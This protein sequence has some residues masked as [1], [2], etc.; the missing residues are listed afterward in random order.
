MIIPYYARNW[1]I[2]VSQAHDGRRI[3]HGSIRIHAQD[4]T[5][6]VYTSTLTD[7][8][9]PSYH[10]ILSIIITCVYLSVLQIGH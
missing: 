4:A 6:T 1:K 10:W 7:A 9:S 5:S 2:G 3:V 8:I